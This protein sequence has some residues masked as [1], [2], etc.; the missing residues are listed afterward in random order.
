MRQSNTR[1]P[2]ERGVPLDYH[3][4]APGLPPEGDQ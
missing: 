2:L 3:G 1:E 4:T